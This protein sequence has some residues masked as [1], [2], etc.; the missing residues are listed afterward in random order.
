[1]A[2]ATPSLGLRTCPKSPS[3]LT[4]VS[5]ACA[6]LTQSVL[7]SSSWFR[8]TSAPPSFRRGFVIALG[9]SS[10]TRLLYQGCIVQILH[11][12]IPIPYARASRVVFVGSSPAWLH[13]G[14]EEHIGFEA[15]QARLP[16]IGMLCSAGTEEGI[17]PALL[18]C[19]LAHKSRAGRLSSRDGIRPQHR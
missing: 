4:F 6:A 19:A 9:G 15:R 8:S 2:K 18:G 17:Q 7:H 10:S 13:S 14:T 16:A 3:F 12:I 11:Y 5:P 1:M